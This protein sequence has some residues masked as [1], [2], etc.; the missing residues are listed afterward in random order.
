MQK[1]N[2][3][4]YPFLKFESSFK[5]DTFNCSQDYLSQLDTIWKLNFSQYFSANYFRQ[6]IKETRK[7]MK[8]LDKISY[9][10]TVL[11]VFHQSFSKSLTMQVQ[12]PVRKAFPSSSTDEDR[13]FSRDERENFLPPRFSLAT[14]RASFTK[15]GRSTKAR[16]RTRARLLVKTNEEKFYFFSLLFLFSFFFFF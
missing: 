8:L 2:P 3:I 12:H 13:V 10:I 5:S 11:L 16:L 4:K 6:K 1:T 15:K 14:C 9:T 7:S